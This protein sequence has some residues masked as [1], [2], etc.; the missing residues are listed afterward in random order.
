MLTQDWEGKNGTLRVASGDAV[1]PL[2]YAG[3][4]GELTG[5]EIALLLEM[6]KELD[7]HLEFTGMEL[8][9]LLTSLETG[10]ADIGNS[11]LGITKDRLE[12]MDFVKY[13]TGSYVLVTRSASERAVGG[14][15]IDSI[16]ESFERT[17]ITD[18][19]YKM[20]FLGL[21]RTIIM[22]VFAGVLGTLV[23]FALVFLR[24]LRYL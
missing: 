20:I 13:R 14:T 22:A 15:F 3:K 10:K 11:G 19:R 16:K 17:F 21:L 2:T 5:M 7:V 1:P 23:G 18:G 6:A 24:Q 4:D 12:K 9:A 8:S